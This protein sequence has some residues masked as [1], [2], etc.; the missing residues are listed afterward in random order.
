MYNSIF[1]GSVLPIHLKLIKWKD[2]GGQT[3]RYYLM[4]EISFKW[5]D[6]G[7]LIGLSFAQLESISM[8]HR[9]KPTECC[10]AVLGHWFDDPPPDYP[11]TWKGLIE[12]LEDCQ[13]DQTVSELI[14]VLDTSINV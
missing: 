14:K 2:E 13:L 3:K 5:H 1:S 9:E 10:R 11:V 8:E 4:D 6:I 12:L 7:V